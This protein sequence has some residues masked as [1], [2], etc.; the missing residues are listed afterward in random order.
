ML[1][2]SE[3]IILLV[4]NYLTIFIWERTLTK[5]VTQSE[6][7]LEIKLTN[8]DYKKCILE[9][10]GKILHKELGDFI[11]PVDLQLC[12]VLQRLSWFFQSTLVT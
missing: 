7:V 6:K 3:K 2:N 12:I 5:L 10:K 4:I 9:K 1:K 8:D 11:L